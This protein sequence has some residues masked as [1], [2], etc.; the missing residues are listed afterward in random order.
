MELQ[1]LSE[2][3]KKT[4]TM[5]DD[6]LEKTEIKSGFECAK[7]YVKENKLEYIEEEIMMAFRN[8]FHTGVKQ[9]RSG[10]FKE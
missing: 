1:E 7:E 6:F 5:I 2:A 8:G 10:K 4:A 9:E 3:L